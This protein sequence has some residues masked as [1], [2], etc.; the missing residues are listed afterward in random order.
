MIRPMI[1]NLLQKNRYSKNCKL[2][3]LNEVF[4]K[5]FLI[6]NEIDMRVTKAI[7]TTVCFSAL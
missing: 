7:V 6:I 4:Y 3:A 2:L 1:S 5:K